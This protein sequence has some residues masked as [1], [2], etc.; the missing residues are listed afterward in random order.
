MKAKP[1]KRENV[2]LTEAQVEIVGQFNDYSFENPNMTFEEVVRKE[3]GPKLFSPTPQGR[4]FEKEC[5]EIFDR[6]RK[7]DTPNSAAVKSQS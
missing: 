3:F 6:E 5:R 7:T 4:L 2:K 1:K